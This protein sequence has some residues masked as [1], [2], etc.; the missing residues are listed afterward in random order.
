MVHPVMPMANGNLSMG[1][2][3][4]MFSERIFLQY[5]FLYALLSLICMM[6]YWNPEFPILSLLTEDVPIVFKLL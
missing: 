5:Y 2:G 6:Q 1:S 3:I 4:Y